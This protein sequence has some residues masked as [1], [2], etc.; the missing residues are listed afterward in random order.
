M[1]LGFAA[2][3][4]EITDAQ[5]ANANRD[6]LKYKIISFYHNMYNVKDHVK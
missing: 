6:L 2:T 4:T 3:S 1:A 5:M